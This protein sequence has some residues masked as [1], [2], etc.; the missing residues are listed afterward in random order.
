MTTTEQQAFIDAIVANPDCDTVR[1]VYADW[2][3]ENPDAD[4]GREE[5]IRVQCELAR[6]PPKHRELFVA[7]GAGN[8]MEGL[9]ICLIYEGGGHYTA[10]TGE[11][12]LS[13]EVFAPSERVDIYADLAGKKSLGSKKGTRWIYGMK[14]VKHVPEREI[15]VFRQDEH[16]GPWKGTELAKRESAVLDQ[17]R[18]RWLACEKCPACKGSCGERYTDAAGSMDIRDC[19]H[20]SG[21]GDVGG[22]LEWE[23]TSIDLGHGRYRY[24]VTFRRGFAH[25]IECR[26]EDCLRLETPAMTANPPIAHQVTSRAKAW[27]RALPTVQEVM[28]AD[29]GMFASVDGIHYGWW[30]ESA[31]AY[32]VGSVPVTI[33]NQMWA[34]ADSDSHKQNDSGRWLNWPTAQEANAALAE[35][36]C[37]LIRA[38]L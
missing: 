34:D 9:G 32:G 5:L 30:D 18:D 15:I 3:Q 16:S 36:M 8:R 27:L 7:D 13:T 31:W 33:F 1:L 38:A 22:L 24:P 17:H 2:L 12:G 4:P 26:M 37:E 25:R 6:L 23:A 28:P 14:Y 11:R 10:S 21:T 20:C 29:L 35:G 19:R